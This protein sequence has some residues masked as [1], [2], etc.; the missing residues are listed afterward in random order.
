MFTLCW[1][2][3]NAQRWPPALIILQEQAIDREHERDVFQQEIQKLEQ[4]LKMPQ[5][6]QPVNEHQSNEVGWSNIIIVLQAMHSF[7]CFILVSGKIGKGHY[8][9]QPFIAIP[10]R[11]IF[12]FFFRFTFFLTE[13]E[14]SCHCQTEHE[15]LGNPFPPP[16]GTQ[17]AI[18]HPELARTFVR[19]S[20][21]VSMRY[22]AEPTVLHYR[23]GRQGPTQNMIEKRKCQLLG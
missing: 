23:W 7:L 22:S 13:Q 19:L 18:K 8:F 14:E 20:L 2:M 11:K 10:F 21:F 6:H 9:R 12:F 4:Q 3:N 17:I 15:I 16:T 1:N 5:R